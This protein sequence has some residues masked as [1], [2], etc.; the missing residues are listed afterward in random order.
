MATHDISQIP[1]TATLRDSTHNFVRHFFEMLVAMVIGMVVLGALV[2]AVFALFGHGNLFHYAALR[3]LLMATYMT[4]GMAIWMRYRGHAW[5]RVEEMGAAMFAPFIVLLVPF[6][7]GLISGGVLLVGGHL[8]M[9]PCMVG[10]ML[11]RRE[12][13][14][15]DHG[16]HASVPAGTAHVHS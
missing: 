3:A 14:S 11:Y 9:L 12:D 2:S 8:L 4:I 13:Y 5:A 16:H 15:R 6:W 7:A 1:P 10:A